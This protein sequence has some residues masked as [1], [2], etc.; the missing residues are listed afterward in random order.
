[1]CTSSLSDVGT[2]SLPK[3]LEFFNSPALVQSPLSSDDDDEYLPVSPFFKCHQVCDK[4][5]LSDSFENPK[6]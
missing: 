6:T 1:M 2:A 5:F 4:V 3:E